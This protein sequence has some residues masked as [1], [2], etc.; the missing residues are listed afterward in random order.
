M[1][2]CIQRWLSLVLQLGV[3]VLAFIVVTLAVTLTSSTSGGRLGV[4]LSTIVTFGQALSYLLMFWTMLET[5]LGAIARLK[6]F[7]ER[8]KSEDKP[9]ETFVPEKEWPSAGVLEFKNVSASYG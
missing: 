2:Y 5:S 7:E 6:N 9:E 3:A 8:T 1:M 4:S